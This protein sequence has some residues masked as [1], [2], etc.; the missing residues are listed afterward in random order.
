MVQ[1]MSAHASKGL[2]FDSVYLGGIYTNGREQNDGGL[3][4]DMPGSFQW[5]LDITRREKQ[6]SPL[7]VFESE[8]SKYK[9]FSEAKRLFYVACTRAKKKLIWVDFDIPE[10]SFSIPKN[11][12]VL[13]LRA[14]LEKNTRIDKVNIIPMLDF[15]SEKQ[16]NDQGPPE[17]PLFFHDSV[18][19]FSKDDGQAE[20]MIAAELSVTRLNA[21][22]DCPRKF[23]YSN[24]L[25]LTDEEQTKK[26]IIEEEED[27][28]ANLV[29]SSSERGTY[30]HAQISKGIE[31]NFV[32]PRESFGTEFE[33]PIDWALQELKLKTDEY[34]LVSEK[35]IKFPFFNFMISG[36]PD[37][38]L[39]PKS[40]QTA[41]VWDFKTGRITVEGLKHYW[42]Q[43]SVYAYSLYE[44]KVVPRDRD[45]ELVLCFVDQKKLIKE[46]VNFEDCRKD[47]YPIWRSQNEPW[48]VNLDHCSQ[49]SYGSICPR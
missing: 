30:I 15:D 40:N 36:I 9:N 22:I 23:Y 18:G 2:E 34:D 41:Q 19:I 46:K 5:Y 1:I 21:L 33:A 13:G 44:L 49:C 32:V 4:G 28:I 37:L 6:K 48:K 25:K 24:V 3:F 35:Q 11:S 20:L 26:E 45:I 42:L 10:K 38:L 17:L 39:L 14:W 16:L 31:K 27:E 29:T 43:L 47:L 8:L 7:Y 12:W